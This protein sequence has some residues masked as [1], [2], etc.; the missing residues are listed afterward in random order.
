MSI[1]KTISKWI[2]HELGMDNID[3]GLEAGDFV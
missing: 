2:D 3:L 1:M